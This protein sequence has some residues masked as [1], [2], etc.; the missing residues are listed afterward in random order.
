M[1]I[2]ERVNGAIVILDPSGRLTF[3]DGQVALNE[4]IHALV[5]RGHRQVVINLAQ[6]DYVDSAGLGELVNAQAIL[7]KAGGR[8]RLAAATQRVRELLSV[9]R[10]LTVLQAFDT[11]AEAIKSLG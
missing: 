2:A 9:T 6:V 11:E 5:D 1:D 3:A 4:R 8:L 10:L 7:S